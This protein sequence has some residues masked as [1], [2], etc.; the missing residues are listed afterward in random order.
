MDHSEA[1]REM[2]VERYL[3][4]ELSL[5]ERDAL[6]EHFFD[7]PECALDVRAAAAF[8]NEAK[9]QLPELIAGLPES[10]QHASEKP[11][12]KPNRWI[13]WW[14]PAFALPAFAAL[15]LV[16]GYQNLVS[17]PELRSAA[18]QPRL[19]PWVPMRGATRSSS[20]LAVV[21]DRRHG[22]AIPIGLSLI[23]EAGSYS[24]YSINLYDPQEKLVW[25]SAIAVPDRNDSAGQTLS[26]VIPGGMLR[27]GQY[28]IAI[29]GVAPNGESTEVSRFAFDLRL[30]N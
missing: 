28:T 8:L 5:D 6:E 1:L 14:R 21:A 26:L 4:N 16:V 23:P 18:N 22:V 27:S 7:C 19:L 25:S 9:T 10:A 20:H 13:S 3:L 15:L 2:A 17:F 12:T 11:A 30:T 29:V 24:S